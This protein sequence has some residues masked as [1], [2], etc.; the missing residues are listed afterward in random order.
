MKKATSYPIKCEQINYDKNLGQ[1]TLAIAEMKCSSK[2]PEY[3]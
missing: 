3:S 2:H 1:Y